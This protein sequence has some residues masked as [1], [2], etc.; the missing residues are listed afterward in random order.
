MTYPITAV[1]PARERLG[2]GWV[3]SRIWRI[4]AHR[5]AVTREQQRLWSIHC[6]LFEED[7]SRNVVVQGNVGGMV[8]KCGRSPSFDFDVPDLWQLDCSMCRVNAVAVNSA[9]KGLRG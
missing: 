1:V 4:F 5:G 9:V 7:A 2:I 8:L 3:W 6:T